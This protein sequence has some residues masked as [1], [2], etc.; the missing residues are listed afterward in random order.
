MMRWPLPLLAFAL[1]CEP[2]ATVSHDLS[3]KPIDHPRD[4]LW[5]NIQSVTNPEVQLD[6]RGIKDLA[7]K[8]RDATVRRENDCDQLGKT[9]P[10]S[11][12]Y[13]DFLSRQ[14]DA[15]AGYCLSVDAYALSIEQAK[16][17]TEICSRA[18]L[19]LENTDVSREDY[20]TRKSNKKA[21][22]EQATKVSDRTDPRNHFKCKSKPGGA[23]PV[24]GQ[25]YPPEQGV[26][27][28]ELSGSTAWDVTL[29]PATGHTYGDLGS[30]VLT[31]SATP[32]TVE[33]V[34]AAS[35]RDDVFGPAYCAE[36]DMAELYK[37]GRFSASWKF[38]FQACTP[39]KGKAPTDRVLFSALRNYAN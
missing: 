14:A 3:C 18:V 23:R 5:L 8:A 21:V 39:L 13:V 12:T 19:L 20:Q 28:I 24:T 16:K 10:N 33:G 29:K 11:D 30:T 17:A 15:S 31:R 9:V 37:A 2:T 26:L 34:R 4:E 22:G 27:D 36:L 35:C 1:S 6:S 25:I 32:F 38:E 7:Q